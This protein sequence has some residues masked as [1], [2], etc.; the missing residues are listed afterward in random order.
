M[1]QILERLLVGQEQMTELLEAKI[2]AIQEKMKPVK[3]K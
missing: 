1:E 2:E 3:M